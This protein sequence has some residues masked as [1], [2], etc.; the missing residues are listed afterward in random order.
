MKTTHTVV[1]WLALLA[2]AAAASAQTFTL[3][4]TF[5][6]SDGSYPGGLGKV[7]RGGDCVSDAPA[8][9]CAARS[10]R[11]ANSSGDLVVPG[12]GLDQV[13]LRTYYQDGSVF[14]AGREY[15]GRLTNY[16]SWNGMVLFPVSATGNSGTFRICRTVSRIFALFNG[17]ALWG[18]GNTAS[19]L[20]NVTFVL[21]NSSGSDDAI[22]V[23][24]DNFSL[25][26]P[27]V[28]AQLPAAAAS[29]NHKAIFSKT[30]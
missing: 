20:T 29:T 16:T 28:P 17:K 19:S 11:N 10:G 7:L 22:S 6:G 21:Q 26:S 1:G 15:N 5:T 8:E 2:V 9:R 25:T 12:P 18:Q 24:F 4:H 3:L 13:E 14:I 30:P 27:S 23:S